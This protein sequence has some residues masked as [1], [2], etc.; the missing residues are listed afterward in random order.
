MTLVLLHY[1]VQ[2]VWSFCNSQLTVIMDRTTRTVSGAEEMLLHVAIRSADRIV[3]L[4]LSI[5]T[6][7]TCTAPTGMLEM[8]TGGFKIITFRLLFT[9]CDLNYASID[10]FYFLLLTA[11]SP[12]SLTCITIFRKNIYR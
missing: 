6:L 3:R 12:T 1:T 2:A 10:S 5:G 9:Y 11:S 4:H 8:T 7:N